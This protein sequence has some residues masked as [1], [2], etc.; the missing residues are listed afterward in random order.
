MTVGATDVEVRGGDFKQKQPQNLHPAKPCVTNTVWG[1]TIGF[2]V[3][4][5]LR[6]PLTLAI[7]FVRDHAP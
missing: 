1:S 4:R 5:V 3:F 2:R 7:K 6:N